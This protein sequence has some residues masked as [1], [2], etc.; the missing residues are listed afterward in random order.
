M[1]KSERIVSYTASELAEMR[2][3]GEGKTDWKKVRALTD[4]EIE[5]SIDFEDEGEFDLST[6]RATSG[7]PRFDPK[8][9]PVLKPDVV[10][11]FQK[12]GPDYESKID[13]VLRAYIAEHQEQE[14][15]AS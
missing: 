9:N 1:E 2:R 4:E 13:A 7:F 8:P 15:K 10:A 5:A 14:R 3:R 12:R 6:A 11:W